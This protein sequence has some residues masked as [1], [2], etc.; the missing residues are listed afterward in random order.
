LLVT[1]KGVI[2]FVK[3]WQKHSLQQHLP[4]RRG[5]VFHRQFCG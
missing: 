2:R 4:K 3:K 5:F 1:D